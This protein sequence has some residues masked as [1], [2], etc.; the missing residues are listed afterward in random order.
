VWDTALVG[1]ALM[2]VGDKD[3]V[4]AAKRGL[5]WLMP[6]QECEVKGDWAERRPE[7][8]PG[9]WAFQLPATPTITDLDDT[10]CRGHGH[11]PRPP[12]LLSGQRL[13]RGH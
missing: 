5:D 1:H 11:G 2:E 13:R 9:G 4:S 10:A 6:L 12:R 7:L 8:R 3:A